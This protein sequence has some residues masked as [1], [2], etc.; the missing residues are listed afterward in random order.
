MSKK[1][2]NYNCSNGSSFCSQNNLINRP[3]QY[4]I[5][6]YIEQ[7]L[8]HNR[9]FSYSSNDLFE[10]LNSPNPFFKT[11]NAE[12]IVTAF[13]KED[14]TKAIKQGSKQGLYNTIYN[15]VPIYIK[16]IQKFIYL[17]TYNKYNQN[18]PLT[19]TSVCLEGCTENSSQKLKVP[20]NKLKIFNQIDSIE[21]LEQ[22][23]KIDILKKIYTN[24]AFEQMED[25]YPVR[26]TYL[27]SDGIIRY[28]YNPNAA[29]LNPQNI[30]FLWSYNTGSPLLSS[31]GNPFA[32]SNMP[33]N[34]ARD[35]KGSSVP[36]PNNGTILRSNNRCDTITSY[37]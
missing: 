21:E 34:T 27:F 1:Y 13:T 24:N 7:F 10:A 12:N 23:A 35:I 32:I 11:I 36:G 30:S 25:I 33:S 4:Q 37:F 9:A 17:N 16:K 3:L 31:Y 28:A 8:F 15:A 14:V 29:N 22:K 20:K 2:N 19:L 26:E 5:M 18:F 6:Y